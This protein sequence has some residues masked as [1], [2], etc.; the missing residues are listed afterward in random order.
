MLDLGSGTTKFKFKG[1]V[2]EMR[3]PTS[4]D[5]DSYKGKLSDLKDDDAKTDALYDFLEEQG[6]SKK[7][8]DEI[9][10]IH[11]QDIVN[12]LVGNGS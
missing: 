2:H 1:E 5:F 8:M 12:L 7:V 11:L 3:L 6:L 10:M 9:P 4:K